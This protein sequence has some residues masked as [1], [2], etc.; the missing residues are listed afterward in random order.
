MGAVDAGIQVAFSADHDPDLTSSHPHN[1]SQIPL[2]LQDLN[3]VGMIDLIDEAGLKADQITGVVGGPPCQG[4]SNMGRREIL[5]P[6]NTLVARFFD[7]VAEL[8]PPFFVF[9]NVPGILSERFRHVLD[10]SIS[11]L[12]NHYTILGPIILNASTFGAATDRPRVIVIGI[13]QPRSPMEADGIS[14]ADTPATVN[15]AL[16]GLPPPTVGNGSKPDFG[17]RTI[18][19]NDDFS[20][21][22]RSMRAPPPEVSGP[23]VRRAHASGRVSGFQPTRHS[24]AVVQRFSK[25]A[26]GARDSVSWFPRLHPDR[27]APTLRAG[28]GRDRGSYQSMRPIHPFSPRV[29]TVREAARL[30]GF[31]DWFVFH[32]TKWHSFRMIG[33]SIVPAMARAVF[34]F[35]RSLI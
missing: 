22:A 31:P 24:S 4:F 35:C 29:I 2:L 34:A 19:S 10:D 32:R 14:S 6:R 9:E 26:P 23:M 33:N 3:E 18:K 13:D 28:T 7:L 17:W 30:Q 5:D 12:V 8:R 20:V 25:I 16:S 21:Y 15:D 27:P 11:S 1:F